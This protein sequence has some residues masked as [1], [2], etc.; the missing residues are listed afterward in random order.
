VSAGIHL[1]HIPYKG[2]A[3]MLTDVMG[4][5]LPVAMSDLAG[6]LP[7][8]RSG[9]VRAL[10][11]SGSE[12]SVALPDVPTFAESGI[13]FRLDSWFALFAP[14]RTPAPIVEQLD[15]AMQ[16]AMQDSAAGADRQP[17]HALRAGFPRAVHQPDARRH[18]HLGS[19]CEVEWR[20]A[21]MIQNVQP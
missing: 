12:R 18:P 19:T 1:R 6:T 5:T 16:E 17:R 7:L 11:V 15:R 8:I 21:R 13:G 3:P 20:R 2:V 14:S 4:G 9:K 10:A